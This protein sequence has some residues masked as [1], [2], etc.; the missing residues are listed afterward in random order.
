[1][2]PEKARLSGQHP[3]KQDR[4]TWMQPTLQWFGNAGGI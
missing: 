3:M 4:M 2:V 1:M